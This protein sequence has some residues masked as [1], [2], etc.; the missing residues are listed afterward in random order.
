M[1]NSLP[2]NSRLDYLDAVRGIAL[3][4]GIFFHAS[5]SFMPMYIGWA[6]MDISTSELIPDFV[7]ISHSFRMELFFLIAGFFAHMKFHQQGLPAF[8]A[9]RLVRIGIPF[10][11]GWFLLRPMLVSGWIMGA[12]S[13]RGEADIGSALSQGLRVLTDIPKDLLVGTHLWFLY[14]LLV[15]SVSVIVIRRVVVSYQPLQPVLAPLSDSIIAWLCQSRLAILAVAIPTAGCL[16][17]MDHWGMDTPD[18]SLIPAI[19]VVLIYAGFFLFGWLLQRQSELLQHFA[20]LSW[21]KFALC[22]M[23]SIASVVLSK[24]EGQ[25]SHPQYHLIKAAFLLNYAIMMWALIALSLGLCK[26][27]FTRSSNF[28]RFIADSSY[29][30]YLI[31]LPIVIWLQVAVAELPLHWT[32]KWIGICGITL[33]LSILLYDLFVRSTVIGALLNGKRQPRYL[34]KRD[35]TQQ[36]IKS[37]APGT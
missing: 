20:R 17:F 14:Y 19:P 28:I 25:F 1:S 29:W 12:E 3:I 22:I 13:M 5:L 33:A 2:S 32:V 24:F 36:V 18:K 31:H 30:L 21:F 34:F 16:W 11:L 27:V 35:D 9:S 4:L 23:A 10:I 37:S 6:V 15:I 8:L 26:R 7:I